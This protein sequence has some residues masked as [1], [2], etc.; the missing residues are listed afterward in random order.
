MMYTRPCDLECGLLTGHGATSNNY[1]WVGCFSITLCTGGTCVQK[2][3]WWSLYII[4]HHRC[5][6][7][8]AH[9]NPH[10]GWNGKR[11]ES[12]VQGLI[13]NQD[14]SLKIDVGFCWCFRMKVTLFTCHIDIWYVSYYLAYLWNMTVC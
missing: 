11:K 10:A 2:R 7:T 1:V 8:L 14:E 4:I 12:S 13:L 3:I 5:E 6:V 9:R